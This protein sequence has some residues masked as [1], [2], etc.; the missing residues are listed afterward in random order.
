M[1][2]LAKPAAAKT[3]PQAPANICQ[4]PPP[5]QAAV[6]KNHNHYHRHYN[7]APTLPQSSVKNNPSLPS[8]MAFQYS[9][10]SSAIRSK[11]R[12]ATP[13]HHHKP[14]HLHHYH[15]QHG[16]NYNSPCK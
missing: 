14:W 5:T 10:T 2:K 13:H 15:Q 11:P 6:T 9:G 1:T 4:Q 7:P 16:R 3:K 8:S 12:Q